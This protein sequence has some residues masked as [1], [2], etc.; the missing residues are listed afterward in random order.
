[1]T[2]DVLQLIGKEIDLGGSE[3]LFAEP[4]SQEALV[5]SWQIHGGEWLVENGWLTGRSSM[6]TSAVALLP[7]H[8]PGNVLVDFEARTV[9]PYRHGL[10]FMWNVGWDWAADRRG[11]AYIGGLQAWGEEKVG[12]ERSPDYRLNAAIPLFGFEPG[13][14]Y[15]IQGGSIDG[16]CF[17]FIDGWLALEL[18]DPRP[19]DNRRFARVGFEAC[20]SHIQVRNIQVRRIAWRA[21][22]RHYDLEH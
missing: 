16:H 4:L 10:H 22:Y 3:V 7:G 2:A 13:R 11:T 8:Y 9:S 18:M 6:A 12:L 5:E 1:M 21:V 17:I 19:I 15:R 14:I 20:S